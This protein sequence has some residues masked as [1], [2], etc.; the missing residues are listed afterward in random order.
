MLERAK[1]AADAGLDS[2]FMGDHHVTPGPYYQNTP[3]LARAL[4]AW[5]ADAPA[6]APTCCP[7]AIPCCWLR[8]LPPWLHDAAALYHAVFDWLW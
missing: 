4:A 2:L 8:R 1:A 6:G 5:R 7:F 3:I